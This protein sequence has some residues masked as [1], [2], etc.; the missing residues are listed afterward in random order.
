MKKSVTK[1]TNLLIKW[2][3]NYDMDAGANL[4]SANFQNKNLS[5]GGISFDL[6]MK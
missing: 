1:G 3:A 6:S 4:I 2:M 5:L